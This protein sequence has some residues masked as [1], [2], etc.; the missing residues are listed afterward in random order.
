MKRSFGVMKSLKVWGRTP[1][2]R[3]AGEESQAA[4]PARARRA[5]RR[6]LSRRWKT[7]RGRCPAKSPEPRTGLACIGE[8]GI[9]F[10]QSHQ[11][12]GRTLPCQ[13]PTPAT[14]ARTRCC[15]RAFP[16]LAPPRL[17]HRR[18]IRGHHTAWSHGSAGIEEH[19]TSGVSLFGGA[20]ASG[21]RRRG[22]GKSES[23]QRVG[24]RVS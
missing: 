3:G 16:L 1:L 24:N 7:H 6:R 20:M 2:E 5:G 9:F 14:T 23:R 4:G 18:R 21:E 15:T 22:A 10:T 12:V 17:I 19:F 11:P 13:T 8:D